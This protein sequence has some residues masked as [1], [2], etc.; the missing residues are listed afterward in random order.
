MAWTENCLLYTGRYWHHQNNMKYFPCVGNLL[1]MPFSLLVFTA[2]HNFLTNTYLKVIKAKQKQ[3]KGSRNLPTNP[4]QGSVWLS[5]IFSVCEEFWQVYAWHRVRLGN[6]KPVI[7]CPAIN[8]LLVCLKSATKKCPQGGKS[9]SPV[10][11]GMYLDTPKFMGWLWMGSRVCPVALLPYWTWEKLFPQQQNT[12]RR[13]WPRST[14]YQATSRTPPAL[15]QG[16]ATLYIPRCNK[17]FSMASK[18]V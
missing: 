12:D 4:T 11:C 7:R 15:H 2:M 10:T 3:R 16:T 6:G 18:R 8:Y 5:I 13:I 14:T 1:N 17:M 9:P